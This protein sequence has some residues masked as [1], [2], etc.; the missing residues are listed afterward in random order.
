MPVADLG[1]GAMNA[2]WSFSAF[3]MRVW[4]AASWAP[5]LDSLAQVADR[6]GG[7]TFSDRECR[8]PLLLLAYREDLHIHR[9]VRRLPV[10]RGVSFSAWLASF[11]DL[12]AADDA[13][14][15]TPVDMIER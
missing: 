1:N 13:G 15:S 2:K 5:A 9:V 7:R 11:L 6:V 3:P 14:I 12:W 4:E 8:H 10:N